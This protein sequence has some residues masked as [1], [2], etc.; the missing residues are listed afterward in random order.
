M[1][2][3]TCVSHCASAMFAGAKLVLCC[4][5]GNRLS[6]PF[7]DTSTPKAPML[8]KKVYIYIHRM[9]LSRRLSPTFATEILPGHWARW[10][11][12]RWLSYATCRHFTAIN[13]HLSH[14]SQ[15]IQ[16]FCVS[17]WQQPGHKT[18]K[19]EIMNRTE[20]LQNNIRAPTKNCLSCFV[21]IGER[22]CVF[23]KTINFYN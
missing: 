3:L 23:Q 15:E 10:T 2:S 13:S 17:L 6:V 9:K 18:I 14:I 22:K 8:Q 16:H 5:V 21:V 1:P 19:Q 7:A 20:R 11:Q 12:Q 4:G